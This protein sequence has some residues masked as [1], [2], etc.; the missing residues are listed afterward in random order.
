MLR[1]TIVAV[2]CLGV[3]ACQPDAQIHTLEDWHFRVGFSPE[4]LTQEISQPDW[5]P[6]SFPVEFRRL[7]ELASHR[8]WITVKTRFPEAAS[9]EEANARTGLA[10]FTG[11]SGD[12]AIYYIND[13]RVASLGSADPYQSGHEL[14]LL[15][16]LPKIGSRADGP[17]YLTIA[18]YSPGELGLRIVGPIR[19]GADSEI[20]KLARHTETIGL[21]LL[22][23]YLAVGVYHLLLALW[24]PRDLHNLYFGLFA[25]FLSAYWFFRSD[26]SQE[27]FVDANLLRIRL[28]IV[29]LLFLTPLFVQFLSQVLDRRH[30][31][32][33]LI[34]AGAC[35]LLMI[36]VAFG[37]YSWMKTALTIWQASLIPMI[38]YAAF[39]IVRAVLRRQADAIFL[40]VGVLVLFAATI[41]DILAA[42]YIIESVPVARYAFFGLVIGIAVLLASRFVRVHN[43]VEELNASLEQKV[44]QRT[45]ELQESLRATRELK[46]MQ[47]GDYFLTSL[48]LQPLSATD[49]IQSGVSVEILDRQYKK[50][51][52]KNQLR[53]IGGDF[54]AAHKLRLRNEDYLVFLNADAM[55]KS[56]QGAGGALVLGTSYKSIINRTRASARQADRDPEL[57][58]NDCYKEI[59]GIF[60]TFDG[61]MLISMVL[62]LVHENSGAMYWVNAE[63]PASILYR[64][65]RASF[66]ENE[67]PLQ[68][69][70]I[71][72]GSAILSRIN[73][74]T[75]R[76]GDVVVLGSDGRD[77][78]LLGVDEDGNRVLNSD[79]AEILKHV[80]KASGDLEGVYES[81]LQRGQL[82]DDLSLV[83]IGFREDAAARPERVQRGERLNAE[84]H[85]SID[86]ARWSDAVRQI[87][88][89]E[90]E[91]ALD[92]DLL[93]ALVRAHRNLDQYS[94]AAEA[95]RRFLL[96][97]PD[98]A[99]AGEMREF[100]KQRHSKTKK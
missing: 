32:V 86:G 80:E 53:E 68:K 48:L 87:K 89:Y 74:H 15:Q 91:F 22:I 29:S 98:H 34:Y 17:D 40:I 6:V 11:R 73:T 31:R 1:R 27:L 41:H 100:L 57:W 51:A 19:L 46:T 97:A 88:A 26:S 85:A 83:R 63:H 52:F 3:F 70:G 28:D 90:T 44:E 5:Q 2:L 43:R 99:A 92:L 96:R 66:F 18:L 20:F 69:V 45:A 95:A 49:G 38:P 23:V 12:V 84:I 82:T 9:L 62:G 47:D 10:L 71:D 14:R 35:S 36:I 61:S 76:D 78:I 37:S 8:G 42:R 21:L 7:P 56:M 30:D 79:D 67:T 81:L 25:V 75:L 55:G 4:Y 33:G 54:C 59:Q 94:Q 50:F 93:S 13:Q 39:Y 64:D 60:L 24:R 58:L 16:A 72:T 77:D 65:G